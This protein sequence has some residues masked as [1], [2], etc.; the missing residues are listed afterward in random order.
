MPSKRSKAAKKYTFWNKVKIIQ[1]GTEYFNLLFELINSAE[2]SIHLQTYIFGNDETGQKVADA[3]MAAAKRNV[4]V[5]L[6]ADGYASQSL[7]AKMIQAFEE[8]GVHFRFFEPLLKSKNFYFGRRLHHKIFV[9]DGKYSLTGGINIADRYN[10]MP[11]I[12]AWLDFALYAEGDISRELCLTC[13]K[14][15]DGFVQK[16]PPNPCQKKIAFDFA[17]E[18]CTKIGLRRN[19]WVRNKNEIS[20]TYIQLFRNAQ[21]HVTILCS[22]FLPGKIIRKLLRN[23]SR[24]GVKIKIITAGPSDVMLSKNA[25]RW[26]YDWLLRNNIELY[27]YQT[28]VLH[29][30]VAVCDSEWLT[31]GSYNINNIS[32]YA[33]IEVNLDVRNAAIAKEMELR[34]ETIIEKECKHITTEE[35]THTKSIFKQ[36]VQWSSYQVIRFIFYI[37]TFYYKRTT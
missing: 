5:Y 7:S 35:L 8:S 12:A 14:T 25:E 17:E 26:M 3:L 20:T 24:R 37:L 6:L 23:A 22:Y 33:S 13:W 4:N 36:F 16:M 11:G 30:K 27:E 18:D 21:S 10:D 9:S 34:L 1:G 29:G 19:D 32:A 31:I 2:E 28:T 15:W